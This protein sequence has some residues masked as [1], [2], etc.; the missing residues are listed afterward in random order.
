MVTQTG[1]RG[2]LHKSLWTIPYPCV[3]ITGVRFNG[4]NLSRSEDQHP[5]YIIQIPLQRYCLICGQI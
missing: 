4:Y 5:Y 2:S 1:S 3:R